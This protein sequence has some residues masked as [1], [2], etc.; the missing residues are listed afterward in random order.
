MSNEVARKPWWRR[1]QTRLSLR[2]LMALVLVMGGGLGWVVYRPSVQ[3]RAVAAI[4]AAGGRVDYE[5]DWNRPHANQQ[6]DKSRWPR[7]LFNTLGPDYFGDVVGVYFTGPIVKADDALMAQIGRLHHLESLYLTGG[8]GVTDAGLVH[9]R[10]LPRL[11]RLGLSS[12]GVKGPGLIH[13]QGLTRLKNLDLINLPVADADLAHLAGL[14]SLEDLMITGPGVTDAGMTH[15][16]GLTNLK[17]LQIVFGQITASG[18]VN[19]RSM[20]HLLFLNLAGTKVNRLDPLSLPIEIQSIDLRDTPIDDAGLA[21]VA[22]FLNLNSLILDQTSISDA[23]LAYLKGLSKLNQLGLRGTSVTD[24]GIEELI[25]FQNSRNVYLKGTRVTAAGIAS[26]TAKCPWT[27][28][29][30]W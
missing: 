1:L 30:L 28:V 9:L 2:V 27:Q 4:R 21:S 11:E 3:R 18:L 10:N 19:L 20:S 29:I 24:K 12:T 23:G 25:G 14:T 5:W 8:S 26:M 15:L 22:A 7:W 17:T 16:A 6:G 13:I